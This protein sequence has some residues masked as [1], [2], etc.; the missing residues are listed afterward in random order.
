M[1]DIARDILLLNETCLKEEDFF[2][3]K[4]VAVFLDKI[5]EID[6]VG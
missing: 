5:E 1:C 4:E 6:V 3:I 2:L